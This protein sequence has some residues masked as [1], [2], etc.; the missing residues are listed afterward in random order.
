MCNTE[1][2]VVFSLTNFYEKPTL[3]LFVLKLTQ[4]AVPRDASFPAVSYSVLCPCPSPRPDQSQVAMT[5]F[6]SFALRL[7]PSGEELVAEKCQTS[8]SWKCTTLA[9]RSVTSLPA[10]PATPA[11][12]RVPHLYLPSRGPLASP[13]PPILMPVLALLGDIFNVTIRRL[14]KIL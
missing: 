1:E 2:F 13:S 7:P 14:L 11:A 8:L 12:S 10:T 9:P 3:S 6:L 5:T 4:T